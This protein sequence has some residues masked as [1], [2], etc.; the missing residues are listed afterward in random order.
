MQT[1]PHITRQKFVIVIIVLL[2]ICMAVKIGIIQFVNHDQL[3]KR[4]NNQ[5]I[6]TVTL[7]GRRGNIYDRDGVQLA[8]NLESASYGIR[9][10][11]IENINKTALILSEAT[12]INS[13]KIISTLDPQ[14][15]FQW[16][17]RQ[18]D[19]STM[20]NLDKIGLKCIEKVP[21][22]KRYYPFGKIAAQVIGYTDIDGMGIEGCEF[23]FN[24][25]L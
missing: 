3:H 6:K 17:V 25:E 8:M 23:F 4:A 11:Y 19:S 24:I 12:G 22:Q 1:G 5:R 15:N 16:L 7:K 9:Y 13:Q 20:E 2:W 10:Q 18:A 14:K 21:E